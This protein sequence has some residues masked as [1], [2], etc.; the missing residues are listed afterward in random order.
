MHTNPLVWAMRRRAGLGE[1]MCGL[2][3]LW[4][5][6]GTAQAAG[7]QFGVSAQVLPR[8]VVEQALAGFPAP[9]GTRSMARLHNGE[10][11]VYAGDASS[12]AGFYRDALASQGYRLVYASD[13]SLVQRWNGED[14][15]LHVTLA[16]AP[17]AAPLT[18]I[19][20][21]V[22]ARGA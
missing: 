14:A 11:F 6:A 8:P 5:I 9:P 12:A 1:F 15:S 20:V 7:G 16:E 2:F 3:L 18:R 22:N 4:L 17:G 10:S 19:V 13:D 21:Q